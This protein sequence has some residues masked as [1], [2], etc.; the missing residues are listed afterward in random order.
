MSFFK[1]LLQLKPSEKLFVL[2]SMLTGFCITSEYGITRPA[3]QSIFLSVFSAES[4]PYVWLA[5]VPFNFFIISLYNRF[6][7]RMGPLKMMGLIILAIA[8]INASSAFLLPLFPKLIFFQTCFKDIYIL[9]M[10]KQ[11]W[12]MI[13]STITSQK[14]KLL[15]GLIFSCGTCGSVAG[16][17]IPGFFAPLFGSEALFLFT[18]PIYLLLFV[19]YKQAYQQSGIH[20]LHEWSRPGSIR[21]REGFTLIAKNRYLLAVLLLVVFMQLSVALVEYQFNHQLREAFPS[22]DVR[23]AYTGQLLGFVNMISLGL[24]FIGSFVLI[25]FL[26]IR[27][28]HFFVPFILFCAAVGQWALPG[29]FMSAAAF[30]LTKSI[31]F[32]LFGIVREML[33]VPLRIDEKFRAKAVIDVFAYRSSKALASLMLLGL[34]LWVGSRVFFLTHYLAIAVFC[35]WF[36]VVVYLF[37][38]KTSDVLIETFQ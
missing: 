9:L 7:P 2:F 13:H 29:F 26:G 33:F 28:S 25:Q 32:S 36:G 17:M 18:P 21:S 23:T 8:L 4:L 14:A 15:Y 11:L 37:R 1:E 22:Q 38:T 31:D 5:I 30:V 34:Q 24:Q 6:L 27:G 35:L 12:S 3:S 16:S 19:F 20:H 10:F